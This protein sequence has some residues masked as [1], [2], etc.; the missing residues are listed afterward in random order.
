V[1]PH[2]AKNLGFGLLDASFSGYWT[3]RVYLDASRRL[4]QGAYPTLG[5]RVSLEPT[6]THFQA[7]IWGKNLANRAYLS[8][9]YIS[10]AGDGVVFAAPR[11]YG[12]GFRYG[13]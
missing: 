9:E 13:F 2:Y 5:T 12:I 3:S 8:S 10:A 7:Y 11:T 1:T 4:S 6:G